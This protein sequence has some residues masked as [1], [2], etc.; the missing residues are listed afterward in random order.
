MSMIST[1]LIAALVF[2]LCYL[3]DKLFTAKFR[4]KAQHRSGLAVRVNKRYGVFGVALSVL[5]VLA[6]GVGVT[7]GKA[8]MIGGGIVLIM[9][10]CLAVYY[11]THGIFY[12]GDSFLVSTF[13]K[14]D[15]T[16]VY[17]NIK[18]QKLFLVQGGNVIIELYL[19]D[20]SSISLQSSMDGVY[21][22][23]DTAFAGW[24]MQK[25]IDPQTCDFHDP[26]KSWWFPHEEDA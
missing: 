19:E 13:L 15:R 16:Y 17:R 1:L 18:E 10:I 25:G 3:I 22:F 11:L 2:G 20:G 12:D 5:G 9:G 26:S 6:I 8:L 14:K 7:G 23:L 4:S 21:L 24:C